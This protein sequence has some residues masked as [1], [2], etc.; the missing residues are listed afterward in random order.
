MFDYNS[1]LTSLL[2]IDGVSK[3]RTKRTDTT[4]VYEGLSIFMWN[5]TFPDLDIQQ[6][7]STTVMRDF[8]IV[9]Y[10]NLSNIVS[11]IQ[12]ALT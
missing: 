5:P 7:T 4:D 3:I 6:V 11:N 1:L 9:Y 12:I 8:E 2:S 10:N